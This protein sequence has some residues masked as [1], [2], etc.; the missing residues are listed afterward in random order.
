MEFCNWRSMTEFH[1]NLSTFPGILYRFYDRIL[2]RFPASIRF[3]T[4]PCNSNDTK[5]WSIYYRLEKSSSGLR[6]MY[7]IT[8]QDHRQ[9][10]LTPIIKVLKIKFVSEMDHRKQNE[11]SS[12]RDRIYPKQ[13]VRDVITCGNR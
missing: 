3:R 1:G 2:Y 5:Y 10:V 6:Y 8:W 9:K 4:I 7:N 11:H 13:C 12:W